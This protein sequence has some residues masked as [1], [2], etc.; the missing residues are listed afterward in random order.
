MTMEKDIRQGYVVRGYDFFDFV[1]EGQDVTPDIKAFWERKHNWN[2]ANMPYLTCYEKFYRPLEQTKFY[3][4]VMTVDVS[5]GIGNPPM[6][7]NFAQFEKNIVELS[8]TKLEL[9]GWIVARWN[10]DG[11]FDTNTFY[12]EHPG[13]GKARGCSGPI[14]G[15]GMFWHHQFRDILGGTLPE[16]RPIPCKLTVELIKE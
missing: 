16:N 12:L 5:E 4:A 10:Y 13:D 11:T 7:H 14:F 15:Y 2:V 6:R 3:K 9:L 8:E 1:Q